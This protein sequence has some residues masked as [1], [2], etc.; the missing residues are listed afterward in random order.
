MSI[1]QRPAVT[2]L[3]AARH[4]FCGIGTRR[5]KLALN[6]LSRTSTFARALRVALEIEDQ[7]L[8]AKKYHGGDIGVYTY[9]RIAYFNKYDAIMQLVEIC[10]LEGWKCGI[11]KSTVFGA[12][13]VVELPEM[14]QIS[15][16]FSPPSNHV[17]PEY[18]GVWDQK[19]NSTLRKLE[20]A[21][22][23][24]LKVAQL[25]EGRA[26]S[27]HVRQQVLLTDPIFMVS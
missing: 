3:N 19:Q 18:D 12:S 6:K 5:T 27:Q 16:H 14:E 23:P 15:W 26:V 25:I 1:H 22:Q 4:H 17:V 10:K 9:D 11:Q 13:H 2:L 20:K 24:L 7:N 21:I 8:T